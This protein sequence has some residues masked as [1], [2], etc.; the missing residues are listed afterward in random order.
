MTNESSKTLKLGI[1]P[2][3]HPKNIKRKLKESIRG[4]AQTSADD[5]RSYKN[6]KGFLASSMTSPII[7]APFKEEDK[8]CFGVME[9]IANYLVS[10]AEKLED[11]PM[12]SVIMPVHN[13]ANIITSAVNSVLNQTYPNIELIIVDDGSDDGTFELLK[14]FDDDKI[15]LLSNNKCSGVSNARNHGLS[16]AKGKY[17]CYLDSDNLWDERYVSAMVGAFTK[18]KDAEALYSG[19]LLFKGEKDV[20]FAARFGSYNK[21]LLFNRNYIDMNAFCHTKELVNKIGMFDESLTRLVDY[22]LIMRIA[23]SS[24]M[25]SVPVLLSYYYYE[26]ASNTITGSPGYTKH[27]NVVRDMQKQ[28]KLVEPNVESV[29]KHND[30]SIIIP[31]YESL[32]DLVDCLESIFKTLPNEKVEV[33]VV[34]NASSKAVVDYLTQM[35]SQGKIKLILNQI[36]YGFTHAVNQ[37][38]EASKYGN[39]ILIMNNDAILTSGAVEELQIAAHTIKDC[40]ITVPQQVLSGGTKTIRTHVPFANPQFDCDV[41]LSYHHK[42]IEKVPIFHSG[43][44]LE[45]NF[46][47]FFC[48]YIKRNVLDDSVG[49]DPETGRHYRSDRIFCDYIQN[50]MDLKIYYVP[51]AIVFHKLQKSTDI[52]RTE[53][54]GKNGFNEMFSK[55]CW[56]KELADD[57]GYK[58]PKWDI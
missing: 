54:E 8:R 29:L 30:V 3:Y 43:G 35:E 28:R 2:R 25:Y 4:T 16:V 50:V 40:A 32:D 24:Q 49:L 14:S 5:P 55:N 44:Y 6:F 7:N 1:N 56:D 47:P 37:G 9:N 18:L 11:M 45:L 42:N 58:I 12:V 46:A 41:N 38:I 13:R 53:P 17:I 57:L 19:L 52:L 27:L 21:S 26:M 33:I 34:D 20:P 15:V 39:D 36:N 51:Q 10:I 22:D 31:N 23:E 48:V